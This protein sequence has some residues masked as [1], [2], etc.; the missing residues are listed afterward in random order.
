MEIKRATPKEQANRSK[1][2]QFS[3]YANTQF[4]Q[5]YPNYYQGYPYAAYPSYTAAA[6]VG[7]QPAYPGNY[8]SADYQYS[9]TSN[10]NSSAGSGAGRGRESAAYP[11]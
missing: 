7:Y 10:P 6:Y 4:A 2:A 9:G 1:N 5:A 8:G 11:G 3:G